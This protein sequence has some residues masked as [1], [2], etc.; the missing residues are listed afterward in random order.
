MTTDSFPYEFSEVLE[1]RDSPNAR[2]QAQDIS[3]AD[4]NWLRNVFLPTQDARQALD[5]PMTVERLLIGA[6]GIV[7]VDLAGAFLMSPATED[8]SYLYSPAF[9]LEHFDTRNGANHAVL[10]R[11]SNT[12]QRDELLCFVALAI[13]SR[14]RF[15][16]HIWLKTEPIDGAVFLDRRRSIDQQQHQN[17]QALNEELLK[18]PTL[19]ALLGKMLG[20]ELGRRFA[21]VNLASVN[22]SRYVSETRNN[23]DSPQSRRVDVQ[24]LADMLLAHY[25]TQTWPAGQTR[26][27]S[28]PGYSAAPSDTESWERAIANISGT[29][30]MRLHS[31]LQSYWNGLLDSG[32]SRRWFFSEV[33]GSCWRAELFKQLQW[34]SISPRTHHWL[35]GLYPH[36]PARLLRTRVRSLGYATTKPSQAE[37]AN[38][39]VASDESVN[40]ASLF[41]YAY[42]RLTPLNDQEALDADLL[43]ELRNDGSTDALA[44]PLSLGELGDLQQLPALVTPQAVLPQPLF[45]NRL[46]AVISKQLENIDYVLARYRM[47]NGQ[48]A[49]GAALDVAL[50]VRAMISRKLQSLDTR[51]RWSTRLDLS[52]DAHTQPTTQRPAPASPTTTPASASEQGHALSTLKA[53]LASELAK[54]PDLLTFAQSALHDELLN[55]KR[56]DLDAANIYLNQY[57]NASDEPQTLQPTTSISLAEHLLER[58]VGLVLPLAQSTDNGL[59]SR[60][61][62]GSWSRIATLDMASANALVDAA[63]VDFLPRF[64]RQHRSI[65]SQLTPLINKAMN[66]G[67]RHE[68]QQRV[69]IGTLDDRARELLETVLDS[70]DSEG[71]KGLR[72]FIPDV[73]SLALKA[74]EQAPPHTL[75]NCFLITER[76]GLDPLNCGRALLWTPAGGLE[77]FDSLPRAEDELKRRLRT[78]VQCLSLLENLITAVPHAS[79]AANNHRDGMSIGFERIRNNF[80]SERIDSLVDKALGDIAEAAR[81]QL[82]AASLQSQVQSCLLRQASLAHLEKALQATRHSRLHSA[83]PGWLANA[84]AD[85][86]LALAELLD[87]HRQH[88]DTPIDYHHDIPDIRAFARAKIAGLLNR[89][90]PALGLNPDD[91]H[92]SVSGPPAQS[93][94]T[95]TLTDY[96]LRHFDEIDGAATT[97]TGAE[98]LAEGLTVA[99]LN[100][101]I[102]EADLGTHYAALLDSHLSHSEKRVPERQ[103]LFSQHLV[104]QSLEHALRQYL[105]QSLSA[106]AHGLIRHL[107]SMPDGVARLP[108]AGSD[109]IVRPLELLRQARKSA[110]QALGL[111]LIGR[112]DSLGAQV[113]FSPYGARP[114]FREFDNESLF[115]SELGRSGSLRQLVLG[116]LSSSVRQFYSEQVFSTRTVS[117][118]WNT[119][120]G[121]FL[122]RLYNDMTAL[123]KDQL[124]LQGT[125]G[126][127]SAWNTVVHLLGNQLHQDTR[128][129]LG[130]LRMPWLIWQTLPQFKEAADNAWHG[131]WAVAMEEFTSALAQLA[132]ARKVPTV[133]THVGLAPP[134]PAPA[135]TPTP[136]TPIESPFPPAPRWA[137]MHLTREQQERLLGYEVRDIAL[138]DLEHDAAL[139][140]HTDPDTQ[141]Q[142]AAVRG[143]VFQ[144]RLEDRRWRIV[145]DQEP[146]PWLRKDAQDQ[147]DMDLKGRLLGGGDGNRLL[148]HINTRQTLNREIKVLATGMKAIKHLYPDK[149]RRI[150]QAHALTLTYLRNARKRL[151]SLTAGTRLDSQRQLYLQEFFGLR[152]ISRGL[153]Q[154]ISRMLDKLVRELLS[155]ARS[156]D[157]SELY[158]LGATRRPEW[159]CAAFVVECDRTRSIYL[160]ELFFEPRLEAYSPLR[161]RTFNGLLHNMASILL[162]ELSHLVFNTVDIAYLDAFRP[163]YDLLDTRTRDGREQQEALKELQETALSLRTPTEQLFRLEDEVTG[164]WHDIEDEPYKRVLALTGCR[165]L[166]GARQKFR[167]DEARRI[168]IILANAD[169][170]ALMINYLGRPTE[171]YPIFTG[172]P[173]QTPGATP[174]STI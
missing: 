118:L 95:Q 28:A 155:P 20:D 99:H 111:Y 166:Q 26:T 172:N 152:T 126:Q 169:S 167:D 16:S 55:A 72:G 51:E 145:T 22:V 142:Y 136:P 139:G 101:L 107:F 59:F 83:L 135:P 13:K 106:Q 43:R 100:T 45:E 81:A 93:T 18:L 105:Q 140:I 91:V 82:P 131:R 141:R 98:Q 110:D 103:H 30:K 70:P 42:D 138:N 32:H 153:N 67:L 48:L 65:Y 76:G 115:M 160:N 116:R 10:S 37:L 171:F 164:T 156:P 8:C 44:Q 102:K 113:L 79:F 94:H 159:M 157:L 119:I 143:R 6:P 69:L 31:E 147:W 134:V 57:K 127:Q 96:A 41:V 168:D 117:L 46:E 85:E 54:R 11:L 33:M 144:V 121:N 21:G 52:A 61:Q 112:S 5:D 128:F 130:R 86:Q 108:L 71:R 62:A 88:V 90:F 73:F 29:L 66:Q 27:F 97:L 63:R 7:P 162:H 40:P 60:G 84:R 150:K 47:S 36:R 174:A 15:D 129:M 149:A 68:A 56:T 133:G 137:D 89:D 151:Q 23:S 104:W 87:R 80:L 1:L 12:T 124:G 114:A 74:T 3:M 50:D 9:G 161:P 132:L 34:D 58:S 4:R 148:D 75:S 146:G 77:A 158:V 2:E 125:Q 78:P 170:V 173:R 19:A 49:L 123:L 163:F 38:A 35:A 64:L 25:L 53:R 92:L 14:I 24:S 109:I 120:K 17:L 39:F 165:D 154:R 122:T